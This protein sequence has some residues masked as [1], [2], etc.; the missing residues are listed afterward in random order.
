M[1]VLHF[2]DRARIACKPLLDF[3][4]FLP[5]KERGLFWNTQSTLADWQPP[6]EA[7]KDLV[8]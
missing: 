6:S 1:P 8:C 4:T 5:S 3:L 7:E 2:N